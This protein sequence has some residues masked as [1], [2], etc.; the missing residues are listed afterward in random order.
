MIRNTFS[1][2][3]GIGEKLERRLWREGILTW[4]DF[5]GSAPPAF[6]SAPR[7]ALHDE[8]LAEAEE[9]LA[10]GDAAWFVDLLKPGEQ[11]RL[12]DVW[13]NETVYLDIETNGLPAD[14]GGVATVVGLYDGADYRAFVRGE[15]LTPRALTDALAPYKQVVTFFGSVFDIPFLY[16]AL[17][18]FRMKIPHFDLCFAGK[19]VGLGGGLKKVEVTLG[20]KRDG[21]VVGLTGYD[22]VHLWRRARTGDGA[23][24]DRLITYNREDTVNL[25]RVAREVYGRLREASGIEEFLGVHA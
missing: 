15:G 4:N 9:R 7:K 13:R 16:R 23:T 5:V 25:A 17:P 12:F 21:D 10:A 18:G 1:I 2:L 6:L 14:E 8:L 20:I 11:W 19:K 3:C 24:L 22:A